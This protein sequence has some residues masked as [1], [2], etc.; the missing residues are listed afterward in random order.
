MGC[1]V[2]H[3]YQCL[4]ICISAVDYENAIKQGSEELAYA[5][6]MFLGKDRSGKSSVLSGLMG[7]TFVENKESTTLAETRSCTMSYKWMGCD[8]VEGVWKEWSEED[9]QLDLAHLAMACEDSKNKQSNNEKKEPQPT[10][11][12]KVVS[13]KSSERPLSKDKEVTSGVK[14]VVGES[15]HKHG[16]GVSKIA[17]S[18][19]AMSDLHQPRL[20]YTDAKD[21]LDECIQKVSEKAEKLE[22]HTRHYVLHVW[23]CG[24]QPVFL[25]IISAFLTFRTF[26]LLVFNAE[27]GLQEPCGA[28]SICYKGK[29]DPAG[30]HQSTNIMVL[31]RWMRL[32]YARLHKH[33]PKILLVGTHGD[34]VEDKE[35]VKDSLESP[36]KNEHFCNILLETLIIDNTRAGNVESEDIGYKNIRTSVRKFADN[37]KLKTPLSWLLFRM[38]VNELGKSRKRHTL[39]YEEAEQIAE[40]CHIPRVI[41]V[42]DFYRN[43]GVFLYYPDIDRKII[44]IDP[45]WLFKQFSGLLMANYHR[46]LQISIGAKNNLSRYGIL[47]SEIYKEVLRDCGVA[48]DVLLGILDKF[49]IAKKIKQAPKC[50]KHDKDDKYFMPCMLSLLDQEG[51]GPTEVQ[52][53]IQAATLHIVFPEMSFVPPGFFVRLVARLASNEQDFKLPFESDGCIWRDFISFQ[54]DQYNEVNIYEPS[55]LHSVHIDVTRHR[56]W[57]NQTPSFKESCQTLRDELYRICKDVLRWLPT[58]FEFAFRCKQC[59]NEENF[60]P[61]HLQN[62]DCNFSTAMCEGCRNPL[63]ITQ[64]HKFWDSSPQVYNTDYVGHISTVCTCANEQDLILPYCHADILYWCSFPTGR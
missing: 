31:I 58:E 52:N 43:L 37:A 32:I 57:T 6:V 17:S 41:S 42:L 50:M 14:Q 1:D 64:E 21:L 61:L 10:K 60:V 56:D 24:G 3:V 29:S 5:R 26:F 33:N 62:N 44:Y 8:M 13:S 45:Q 12:S 39:S 48:P 59:K 4:F 30:K 35:G 9:E 40:V 7:N 54:Y 46:D 11:L 47:T 51:S 15:S 55:S 34:K 36:C 28:G 53:P 19:T 16:E 27:V 22:R 18:S 23:D 38:V 20:S 49:D 25:D 2:E 63:V